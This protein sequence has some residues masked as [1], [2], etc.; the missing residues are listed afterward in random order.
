MTGLGDPI[1]VGV[2]G[3]STAALMWAA[4]QAALEARPLRLL[5]AKVVEI[6]WAL[7]GR[8]GPTSRQRAA[9]S[10][11]SVVDGALDLIEALHPGQYV[12]GRSEI[13]SPVRLLAREAGSASA[14]VVGNHG[15]SVL[16]HVVTGTI[17]NAI[18]T[19]ARCPLI[20]VT[21]R[22]AW[23]DAPIV[24][25]LDRRGTART[26]VE[27][28]Y[29][30]AARSGVDLHLYHV[31]PR[32]PRRRDAAIAGVMSRHR[33]LE[34]ARCFPDVTSTLF[35]VTGDPLRRLTDAAADA[36]LLVVGDRGHHALRG[37]LT[38]S[39]SHALLR[40][41][42]CPIAVIPLARESP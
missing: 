39:V 26:A 33:L 13:V 5:H 41:A 20:T 35:C 16:R 37:L 2:G 8:S 28:G 18:L 25:G 12:S 4:R 42:P 3:D 32:W 31:F 14:V 11:Q 34:H 30:Q 27:F 36:Q 10:A 15:T 29:A 1:V 7:A 24:I 22:P 6:P 23:P 17:W 40:R 9:G 21:G 38:G 19:R